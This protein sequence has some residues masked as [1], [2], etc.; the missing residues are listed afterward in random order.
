MYH[1]NY[2]VLTS[3]TFYVARFE[4]PHVTLNC[5]SNYVTSDKGVVN[6]T[7]RPSPD[8]TPEEIRGSVQNCGAKINCDNGY[9]KV[10]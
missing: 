10:C 7:W 4:S 5:A 2:H 6:A 9:T 1:T 3:N 8:M